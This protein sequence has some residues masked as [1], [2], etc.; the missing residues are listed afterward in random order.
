ML[1]R[2]LVELKVIQTL[3][4]LLTTGTS[5]CSSTDFAYFFIGFDLEKH[6]VSSYPSMSHSWQAALTSPCFVNHYALEASLAGDLT[7]LLFISVFVE[8]A[9]CSPFSKTHVVSY[10]PFYPQI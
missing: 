10:Q 6:Q 9:V 4:R 7:P 8:L 3:I 1:L 5:N 2:L